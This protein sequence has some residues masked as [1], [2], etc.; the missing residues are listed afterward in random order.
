MTQALPT[1]W[2]GFITYGALTAPYLE[3]FLA[4]LAE[5]TIPLKIIVWD[6]TPEVDNANT[7]ILKNHPEVEVLRSGENIGFS[8]AYNAM[9]RNA[10]AA[11]AEYFLVI[12]P[13]TVLEPSAVRLLAEALAADASL[14]SVAPKLRRWDFAAGQR[15]TILDSCGLRLAPGLSF[16]DGGQGE[17]DRGQCDAAAIIGPSGAAGLFRLAALEAV[18]EQGQYFDEHFFMY[19]EDC[20]LAYRLYRKHWSSRLIATAVVYHDRS[21]SGGGLRSRLANRFSRTRN[22]RRWAF[23]NQHFLFIKFWSCQSFWGKW[24]IICQIKLRFIAALLLEPYLLKEYS[25]I[26][27]Q[28]RSLIKY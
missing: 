8:R 9:I 11:G 23:I 20:D 18:A 16:S 1:I 27:R 6:N 2:T 4:S 14:G 19:K 10:A 13:D 3:A 26:W 17:E 7:A 25:V 24:A 22:N 28:R 21:D 15:T 12:N 5:Q